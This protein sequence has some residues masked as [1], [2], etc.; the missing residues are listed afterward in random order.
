MSGRGGF[1]ALVALLAASTGAASDPR[2]RAEAAEWAVAMSVPPVA[3]GATSKARLEVTSRA[4]YHVNLDYPM[5]FRPSAEGTVALPQSRIGLRPISTSPC[6]AGPKESCAVSLEVPFTAPQEGESR[7]AGALAFSVC[8]AE[9][10]LIE[11]V[12]LLARAPL[13]PPGEGEGPAAAS[14]ER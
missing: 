6:A 7:V 1:L 11:K 3:P 5:S 8:S 10:C 4:G 13:V 9:R 2:D 14:S 12:S